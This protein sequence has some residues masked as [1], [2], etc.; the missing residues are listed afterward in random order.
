ME[1]ARLYLL[2]ESQRSV[3]L[4][5]RNV[6]LADITFDPSRNRFY[7]GVMDATQFITYQ[8]RAAFPSFDIERTNA[9]TSDAKR[10]TGATGSTSTLALFAEGV[11]DDV[12][13]IANGI[14]KFLA[15]DPEKPESPSDLR[16][17]LYFVGFLA[18]GYLIWKIITAIKAK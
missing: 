11:G 9:E 5:G 17:L 18:G 13:N 16:K 1:K 2:P 15:G 4:I 8:Q 7:Y 10:G 6:P 12:S 3:T 14:R